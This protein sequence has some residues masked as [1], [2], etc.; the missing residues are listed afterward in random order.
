[1][2]ADSDASH[3]TAMMALLT[4]ILLGDSFSLATLLLLHTR[5]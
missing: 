1:M 4:T 3:A 2:L 5:G